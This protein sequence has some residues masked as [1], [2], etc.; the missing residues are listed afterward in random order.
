VAEL[1][2]VPGAAVWLTVKAT[3]VDVYADPGS[4]SLQR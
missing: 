3:E 2:L 4:T 1:S